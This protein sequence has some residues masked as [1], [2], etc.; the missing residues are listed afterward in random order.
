MDL[1]KHEILTLAAQLSQ[2]TFKD[3]QNMNLYL[4]ETFKAAYTAGV[5]KGLLHNMKNYENK[6]NI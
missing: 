5:V 6:N 3:A 2:E 1:E 4:T